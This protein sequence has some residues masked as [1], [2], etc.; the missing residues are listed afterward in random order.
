M[1]GKS[2]IFIIL[3]N[4]LDTYNVGS[5]FRLA[6]A[7]SAKKIYLCGETETPPNTKIKKSS[8]NTWQWVQWKYQKSAAKAIN[9]LKKENPKMKIVAI[10]QHHK[11]I[12][13]FDF[14]AVFPLC[15]VVGNETYGISEDVLKM[16]D[17]ILELPMYGINKSLNVM[18]CCGIVL[19]KLMD[20]LNFS[21]K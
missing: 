20:G 10:E 19:Y 3:D 13:L 14:K 6:D 11:S 17:T 12:S 9:D 8:I 18:V 15:L 2:P 16:C 5:I 7:V 4:V 1:L 21:R